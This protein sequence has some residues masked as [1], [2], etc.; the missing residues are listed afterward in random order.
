MLCAITANPENKCS[1][2]NGTGIRSLHAKKAQSTPFLIEVALYIS[3][4]LVDAL[5]SV[6]RNINRLKSSSRRDIRQFTG[7]LRNLA[8]QEYLVCTRI[9]AQEKLE[10]RGKSRKEGINLLILTDREKVYLKLAPK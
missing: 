7:V 5:T 2:R 1:V 4:K 10:K 9:V 3:A 8:G 6:C